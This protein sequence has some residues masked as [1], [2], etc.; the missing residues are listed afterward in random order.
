MRACVRAC[1]CVCVCV[2]AC[3]CVCVC[4]CVLYPTTR[5]QSINTLTLAD[6]KKNSDFHILEPS[7]LKY[8][9]GFGTS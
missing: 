4:V 7:F 8:M 5:S 3:V 1:V 6:F 2:C 9:V